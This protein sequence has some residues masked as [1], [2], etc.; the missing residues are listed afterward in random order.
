[1]F[2]KYFLSFCICCINFLANAQTISLTP[3][4]STEEKLTKF[5]KI[6]EDLRIKTQ[7]PGI[8]L[9]I[10]YNNQLIHTGGLGYRDVAQKLPVTENTLFA[11]G[12]TTKA[13]TGVLAAKLVAK[14][15]LN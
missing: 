11:I 7:V 10:V 15:Q 3:A 6:A 12:S 9:A 5:L 1:M 4:N 14:G 8:G 13:F 2:K